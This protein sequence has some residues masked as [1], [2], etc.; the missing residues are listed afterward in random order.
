[1]LD[2][3]GTVLPVSDETLRRWKEEERCYGSLSTFVASIIER[4]R[5]AEG[6]TATWRTEGPRYPD[7]PQCEATHDEKRCR[8]P[9]GHPGPHSDGI[10]WIDPHWE[11]DDGH[12][13][14]A[15]FYNTD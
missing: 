13:H 9:L 5:Q 2:E 12:A 6:G 3:D 4:L 11:S 10:P 1:M 14:P 8:N 15:A 7:R